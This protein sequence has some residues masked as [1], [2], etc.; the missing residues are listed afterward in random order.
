VRP[1]TVLSTLVAE[2]YPLTHGRSRA[3]LVAEVEMLGDLAATLISAAPGDTAPIE[4]DELRARAIGV[5]WGAGVHSLH[6][7]EWVDVVIEALLYDHTL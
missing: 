4:A 1:T 3:E 2:S 7:E 5:L 6:A